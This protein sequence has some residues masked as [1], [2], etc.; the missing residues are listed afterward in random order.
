MA[1][2]LF[3]QTMVILFKDTPQ[4]DE[5]EVL[6]K[7][8]EVVNR[9]QGAEEWAFGGPTLTVAFRPEVNGYAA[10][11]VVDKPWPD[12]MGDPEKEQMLFGA[13]AMGH[14]G[15]FSYPGC[16]ERA[17][18]QAWHLDNVDRWVDDHKAF[19]RIRLSYVFG[20]D[21]DAKV[22][23]DDCSP[24][25]ELYFV[26]KI[27]GLMLEHEKALCFFNP[28]GEVLQPPDSFNKALIHHLAE[29]I[30]PYDLWSNIRLFNIDEVWC[31]M[32]SVGNWQLDMADHEVAFSP[33]EIDPEIIAHFIRN[34][35]YYIQLNGSVIEDGHTMDDNEGRTW[36]ATI[37]EDGHVAPPRR[38]FLW[39][40]TWR[41]DIPEFTQ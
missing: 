35:S 7:D 24:I 34:V 10:I 14:F 25:N 15:P 41:D 20:S 18:E 23:P 13:W 32:D 17:Q 21:E 12:S 19:V 36:K 38:V 30:P 2:G 8:Y 31:L 26:T 1:K 39:L 37:H 5:L 3:S 9:S 27:S 16:L 11:D 22:Q 4:L 29:D 6:L 28:N 33:K 40:P